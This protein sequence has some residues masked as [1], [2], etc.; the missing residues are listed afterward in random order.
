ML[1]TGES[2]R[3]RGALLEVAKGIVYHADPRRNFEPLECADC[4]STKSW[5]AVYRQTTLQQRVSGG[6]SCVLFGQSTGFASTASFVERR[7]ECRLALPDR[8]TT[9]KAA[10]TLFVT[11]FRLAKYSLSN[12]FKLSR[13]VNFPERHA[14]SLQ[15][16][17]KDSACTRM[18]DSER[19]N[20]ERS[21][22]DAKPG[23]PYERHL[24]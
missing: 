17:F 5:M 10:Q 24:I 14:E 18:P 6:K 21:L 8:R 19:M 7:R 2:A 12:Y 23:C 9:K 1:S 20:V 15:K 4:A 22:A 11:K 13:L 3:Q 16:P